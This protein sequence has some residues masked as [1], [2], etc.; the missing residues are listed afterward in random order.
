M[1]M[2]FARKGT[3]KRSLE[4]TPPVR[5]GGSSAVT[6]SVMA[7]SCADERA[8]WRFDQL[9]DLIG[10]TWVPVSSRKK[11]RTIIACCSLPLRT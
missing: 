7:A 8:D 2:D 10:A 4:K 1:F 11:R 9:A 6:A 3:T 5:T